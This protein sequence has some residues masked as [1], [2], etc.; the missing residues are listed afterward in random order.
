MR[1]DLPADESARQGN[2]E[3]QEIGIAA[4]CFDDRLDG[5]VEQAHRTRGVFYRFAHGVF[6][7][8]LVQTVQ[9]IVVMTEVA[10]S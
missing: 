4:G 5:I 8:A 7:L 3:L 10:F 6:T 1:G 2:H 9:M